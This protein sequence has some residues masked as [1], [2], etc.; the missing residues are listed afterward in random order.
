MKLKEIF[1]KEIFNIVH[2]VT[3]ELEV[4]DD[5][6][7]AVIEALFW[8]HLPVDDA[9]MTQAHMDELV[10]QAYAVVRVRKKNFVHITADSTVN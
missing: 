9:L 4:P 1:K 5:M 3:R 6:P 7:R 8:L 10:A 2:A